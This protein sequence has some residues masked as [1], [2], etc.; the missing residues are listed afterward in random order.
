MFVYTF[1]DVIAVVFVTAAVGFWL[2]V[3]LYVKFKSIFKDEPQP[4]KPQTDSFAPLLITENEPDLDEV[5][6][7]F[8]EYSKPKRTVNACV[9]CDRETTEEQSTPDKNGYSVPLYWCNN[10]ERYVDTVAK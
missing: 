8:R 7:E 10:C 6:R 3:Y 5:E 4:R 1:Q 2:A 9:L